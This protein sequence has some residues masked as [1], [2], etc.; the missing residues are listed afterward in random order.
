MRRSNNEP[1][2]STMC[3]AYGVHLQPSSILAIFTFG[4]RPNRLPSTNAT[5]QLEDPAIGVERG[6]ERRV[7]AL[8]G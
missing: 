2:W 4:K 8:V 7:V 3:N 1:A 5:H 6:V